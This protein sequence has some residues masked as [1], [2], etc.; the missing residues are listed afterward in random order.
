M[1]IV[2]S[3]PNYRLNVERVVHFDVLSVFYIISVL[4]NKSTRFIRSRKQVKEILWSLSVQ[5]DISPQKAIEFYAIFLPGMLTAQT[6]GS[7][8]KK[9]FTTHNRENFSW[10]Y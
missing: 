8:I 7:L 9:M 1:T 3:H 5:G 6:R 10:L 2:L 4:G